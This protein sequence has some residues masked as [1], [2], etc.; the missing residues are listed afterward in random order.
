MFE[1]ADT[2]LAHQQ[3]TTHSQYWEAALAKLT[4]SLLQKEHKALQQACGMQGVVTE[5]I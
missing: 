2:A 5:N 3:Q 4:F 1:T